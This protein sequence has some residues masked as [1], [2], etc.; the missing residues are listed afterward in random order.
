QLEHV[1]VEASPVGH[2][3]VGMRLG[4]DTGVAP[5]RLV[6]QPPH[7]L[8]M[9]C[10][11]GDARELAGAVADA[12]GEAGEWAI[13]SRCHDKALAPVIWAG[14]ECASSGY[15]ASASAR[16]SSTRAAVGSSVCPSTGMSQ[17]CERGRHSSR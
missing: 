15:P 14:A 13:G 11:P 17:Y 4:P 12:G 9:T 6:A 8:T 2:E 10:I 5:L 7:D 16:K 1:G 3:F